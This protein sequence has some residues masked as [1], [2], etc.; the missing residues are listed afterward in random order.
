MKEG[1]MDGSSSTIHPETPAFK[2]LNL[3]E[4]PNNDLVPNLVYSKLEIETDTRPFFKRVWM[5]RHRLNEKSTLLSNHVRKRILI[6]NGNWPN[7]LNN[8]SSIQNNLNFHEIMVSLQGIDHI[9][10]NTQY[11]QKTYDFVDVNVGWRFAEMLVEDDKT[12]SLGVNLEV[13]NDVREQHGGE[14]EPLTDIIHGDSE[15]LDNSD[16]VFKDTDGG[17]STGESGSPKSLFSS[18]AVDA[19]KEDKT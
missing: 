15:L 10:G 9:S 8:Y 12:Q 11:S 18:N 6:N 16:L 3:V 2:H 14:A 4:D 5:I 17:D 13:I 1:S 7:E 19:T